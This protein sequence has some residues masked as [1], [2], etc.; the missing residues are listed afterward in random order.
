MWTSRDVKERGKA[1][2]KAN[3]WRSI[4]VGLLLTLLSGGTV[5]ISRGSSQDM[6]KE[7]EQIKEAAGKL[8]PSQQMMAATIIFGTISVGMII[9]ILLRIFLYNPLKVGAYGF[10]KENVLTGGGGSLDAL[11]N[12]F[13]RFGRT[14]VT[15]FMQDLFLVLWTLLFI[16]PGFVKAYSYRMVPYILEDEPDLSAME[17]ITRSRQIM[18]GNKWKSFIYDLSFIGWFFLLLITF[19]LAGVFWVTPYKYNADAALYLE[20]KKER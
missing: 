11:K 13:G 7:V 18:K 1:A 19:G 8:T 3:Y 20:I 10:F 16:I 2:F 6:Q 9:T 4:L 5:Y 17:V 15:L 14:F 12:G